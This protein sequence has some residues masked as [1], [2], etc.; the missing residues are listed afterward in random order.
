MKYLLKDGRIA[1]VRSG[2]GVNA[3]KAFSKAPNPNKKDGFDSP[4]GIRTLPW[5]ETFEE[6]QADLDQAVQGQQGI[7]NGAKKK[8]PRSKECNANEFC[9]NVKVDGNNNIILDSEYTVNGVEYRAIAANGKS[10]EECHLKKYGETCPFLCDGN[11][12]A[13][14]VLK[15]NEQKPET[16]IDPA[17]DEEFEIDG[18][19]GIYICK[20][21]TDEYEDCFSCAFDGDIDKCMNVECYKN[22]RKDKKDV[23][24]KMVSKSKKKAKID[25]KDTISSKAEGTEGKVSEMN[26]EDLTVLPILQTRVAMN[27]EAIED[28]CNLIRSGMHYK[29]PPLEAVRDIKDENVYYL[30]DGFHR[31]E[32]FKRVADEG[33]YQRVFVRWVPGTLEDALWYAISANQEHG[34]RRTNEDKRNAVLKALE[35]PR[36][37]VLSDRALADWV[38]VSDK[39]V[40]NI[41]KS[42]AEIPQLTQSRGKESFRCGNSAPETIRK[43]GKDGKSYPAKTTRS[44]SEPSF[45]TPPEPVKRPSTPEDWFANPEK[46]ITEQEKDKLRTAFRNKINELYDWLVENGIITQY[47]HEEEYNLTLFKDIS[48]IG[49]VAIPFLPPHKMPELD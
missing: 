44:N 13:I 37:K 11:N 1:Y 9:D 31:L 47:D 45:S 10:C 15:T 29:F 14:F 27:E 24:I 25:I 40:A 4:H 42:T 16:G 12:G 36:G 19:G 5:R 22:R 49:S 6:A 48:F 34:I 18:L 7:F 2:I 21:N 8:S 17:I 23:I 39:T 32:A 3:F 43:I 41:R 20:E 35:H 33:D 26:P 28:Y 38:G 30:Y 46:T